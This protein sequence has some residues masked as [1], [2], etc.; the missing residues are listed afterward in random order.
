MD[1][2]PHTA[3]HPDPGPNQRIQRKRVLCVE[4]DPDSCEMMGLLLDV[5]GYDVTTAISVEDALGLA[6]RGG[7]DLYVLDNWLAE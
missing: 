7:F 6:R 1:N 4:D 2:T 3:K 5:H